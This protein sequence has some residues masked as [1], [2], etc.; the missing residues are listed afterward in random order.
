MQAR[1]GDSLF[2]PF[3]C[4]ECLFRRITDAPSLRSNDNHQRL[5]D[6][7]RRDNS[8]PVQRIQ[9][10]NYEEFFLRDQIRRIF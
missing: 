9:C 2:C 8:G 1:E 6:H 5:L 3:E 10:E 7:I 4:D